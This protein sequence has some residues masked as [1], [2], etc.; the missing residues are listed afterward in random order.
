MN[1]RIHPSGIVK[2]NESKNKWIS[3]IKTYFELGGEQVQHSIVSTEILKVV[4]KD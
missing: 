1:I 2:T 3:L 4:Q